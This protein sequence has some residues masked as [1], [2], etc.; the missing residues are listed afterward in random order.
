[1]LAHILI[2]ISGYQGPLAG[3]LLSNI[4]F[5]SRHFGLLLASDGDSFAT[6]V[7]V[8]VGLLLVIV[9]G[10][11][12]EVAI[13]WETGSGEGHFSLGPLVVPMQLSFATLIYGIVANMAG[14]TLGCGLVSAENIHAFM[15]KNDF[16]LHVFVSR[17]FIGACFAVGLAF[18][19]FLAGSRIEHP[20]SKR[21]L[22]NSTK[23]AKRN[24]KRVN[25][26]PSSVAKRETRPDGRKTKARQSRRK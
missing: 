4:H 8:S 15:D 20:P 24:Y 5:A 14:F 7:S 25:P 21:Q 6:I 16:K 11:L 17:V 3:M 26:K 9:A 18:L 22:Q 1:M 10:K 19:F 23:R 2:P 12:I 13:P